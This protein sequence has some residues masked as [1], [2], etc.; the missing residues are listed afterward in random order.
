M[1]TFKRLIRMEGLNAAYL[2]L[3]ENKKKVLQKAGLTLVSF[4]KLSRQ[5]ENNDR[6]FIGA[7][8][9]LMAEA[10]VGARMGNSIGASLGQSSETQ[11][12]WILRILQEAGGRIFGPD[13]YDRWEREGGKRK[14]IQTTVSNLIRRNRIR[15]G[16]WQGKEGRYGSLLELVT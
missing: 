11:A 9:A 14:C 8:K 5:V 6:E 12:E 15:K 7:C 3:E 4:E 2:A 13:L 10:E 16:P 1:E